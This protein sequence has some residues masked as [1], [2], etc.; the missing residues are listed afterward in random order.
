MSSSWIQW[1][2]TMACIVIAAAIKVTQC[3]ASAPTMNSIHE[4]D[5]IPA[6]DFCWVCINTVM[7]CATTNA[8]LSNGTKIASLGHLDRTIGKDLLQPLT[9]CNLGTK[10]DRKTKNLEL[11]HP[12]ASVACLSQALP[13]VQRQGIPSFLLER[14][15]L[16][17]LHFDGQVQSP[18]L[19]ILSENCTRPLLFPLIVHIGSGIAPV[20]RTWHM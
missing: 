15:C 5:T 4:G 11:H 2:A 7:A 18:N 17:W 13:V 14:R 9:W 1:C 16:Q 6:E 12:L 19:A 8:R 10:A 20:G 3:C